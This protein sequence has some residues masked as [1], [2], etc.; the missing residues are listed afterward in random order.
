[1]GAAARRP[2]WESRVSA[3]GRAD[4][5]A[6]SGAE[7]SGDRC[8]TLSGGGPGES[9]SKVSS[10]AESRTAYLVGLAVSGVVDVWMKPHK[11]FAVMSV[12]ASASFDKD[13]QKGGTLGCEDAEVRGEHNARAPVGNLNVNEI[14]MS[15]C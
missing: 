2:V 15:P 3:W 1:M 5:E 6:A 13:V 11:L 4:G 9:P 7:V 14:L 10:K 12:F 8:Q